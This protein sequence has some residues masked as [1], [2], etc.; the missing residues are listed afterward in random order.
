VVVEFSGN[1]L[2]PCMLD[3]DGEPLAGAAYLDRY[4]ADAEAVVKIF[5]PL[6]ARLYF[7]GAPSPAVVGGDDSFRG[8]RLDDAYRELAAARGPRVAFVD[9]GAAVL[10]RGR[11]TRSLPCLPEEPCGGSTDGS[12]PVNVVRAPDGNHFCPV[13]KHAVSGVTGDCPVWSSGAYRYALA[14]AQPVLDALR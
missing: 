11:W 3:P 14:M 9:A 8:G 1:A 7:A 4:R 2:T 5:S 12:P 13:A 6:E 10:D